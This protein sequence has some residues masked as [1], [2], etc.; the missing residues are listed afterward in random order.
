[1]QVSM[2]TTGGLER[3][4][5]VAVPGDRV[6]TEVESRLK[7]LSRTARLKGFR[8][9][10][11]PY[12]VIQKQF[13]E[14]VRSEVVSD[15]IRSSYS[16]AL[17][18]EKVNPAGSPRIELQP[19]GDLKY[20]ATFE[21]LPEV[22]LAPVS[23]ITV[24]RPS[25]K[26][27][28]SDI[29]A[30]VESMRKQRPEFSVVERASQDTDRVT[31]DYISKVG[32]TPLK[33]GEGKDVQFIIGAGR[34][35]KELEDAVKGAKAGE[36]RSATVDFPAEHPNKELAGKQAVF[37]LTVKQV[38]EQKLPEVNDEFVAAY[39]VK[40]GG[41][42]ALRTEVR[43][44]MNRELDDLI[45]NRLR[46]QVLEALYTANKFDVPKALIE[47]QIQQLQLDMARRANI[48]DPSQLPPANTFEE[49]ARRRVALG[50]ILG[51]I[52]KS[53]NLKVDRERVQTRLN[54]LAAAYP[55]ADEVRRAY[56]QNADA[57]RQIESAV[58]EDQV[59]DWVV[60]KAKIT[61]KPATFSELTGF[62][63]NNQP[64]IG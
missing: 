45:R 36:T 5:E 21:V 59:V 44:S 32:D 19:G 50:L 17:N 63:Q 40:E 29:D 18:Q 54:D 58:L 57:M 41:V 46:T 42:E 10:K 15:L 1:M 38:E 56:L 25:A 13:G 2:T 51:E 64:A 37:D 33:D 49:S 16:D 52:V 11:A 30:M 35:M 4:L 14:Q 60:G 47:E 43:Q 23:D 3:R 26:V 28:D 55:N 9:G 27:E 12:A 39:G 31:V 8:P 62:G 48:T 61:E 24:E 6:N 7:Q 22:R 34:V 53:E 20:T